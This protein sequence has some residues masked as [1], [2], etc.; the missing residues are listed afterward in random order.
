MAEKNK[1]YT[2]RHLPPEPPRAA[3]ATAR[4]GKKPTARGGAG[5]EPARPVKARTATAGSPK[6]AGK[7]TTEKTA[8][9]MP[10]PSAARQSRAQ[11]TAQKR[12]AEN[13]LFHQS[14]LPT[15]EHVHRMDQRGLRVGVIWLLVLP[16]LLLVIRRL[17]DSNKVAFLI[18]WIIGM[19]IISAALIFV[20][21]ADHELK[22]FLEDAKQY[23]PEAAEME[24]G[25]LLPSPAEAVRSLD[26]DSLPVAPEILRGMLARRRERLEAGMSAEAVTPEEAARLRLIEDW[27]QRLEQRRG[28]ET[29]NAEH[30]A[31]HKG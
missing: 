11:A 28:K 6:Q 29:E 10:E 15:V 26:A 7:A 8:R 12:A 2:P 5:Y 25:Q 1:K 31:D 22:R 30:K 20:A 23:V 9:R 16:I 4:P 21:Y 18:I 13:T 17:T 19:F 27:L 14:L 3:R 24:L